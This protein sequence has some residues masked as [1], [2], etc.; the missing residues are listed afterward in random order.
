MKKIL[1]YKGYILIT[2]G[3]KIGIFEIEELFRYKQK[4]GINQV[5]IIVK[6]KPFPSV[7]REA[8]K[9]GIRILVSPTP[10]KEIKETMIKIKENGENVIVKPV[11]DI[12]ERG[13]MEDPC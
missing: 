13:I 5:I 9:N 6:E 12:A 10:K 7:I 11:S 8:E 1:S 3:M 4:T 2:Y